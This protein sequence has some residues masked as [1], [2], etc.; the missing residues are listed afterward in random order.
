M[1][2]DKVPK[3]VVTGAYMSGHL[4]LANAD[5]ESVKRTALFPVTYVFPEWSKRQSKALSKVEVVSKDSRS[6]SATPQPNS[7][8][9]L[10]ETIRDVK[11]GYLSKLSDDGAAEKIWNELY[12]DYPKHIPLLLAQL[13]RLAR[14]SDPLKHLD[15]VNRLV[16]EIL[17]VTD[18]NEVKM[19]LGTKQENNDDPKVKQDMDQRK[20]AIIQALTTRAEVLADAHLKISTQ[21]V[22]TSFRRGI[23]ISEAGIS[24]SDLPKSDIDKK[25]SVGDFQIVGDS[26][27]NA[28]GSHSAAQNAEAADAEVP[29]TP[30]PPRVTLQE[31]D[32]AFLRLLEW[33]DAF[34]KPRVSL[35]TAK[36]AVANAQYGR[37]MKALQKCVEEKNGT[38]T[39]AAEIAMAELASQLGWEYIS[40]AIKNTTLLKYPLDYH[41]F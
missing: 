2:D 39:K 23:V 17:T 26:D 13:T 3:Q 32:E 16:E 19:Y 30:N 14:S 9:A 34:E 40:A 41:P 4:T 6:R 15:A 27:P 36:H 10:N 18:P 25:P 29:S 35:L 28:P 5:Q 12:A 31:F 7:E 38:N 33:V 8:E 22:P 11:I 21:E 24:V 37:A 20:T 1:A